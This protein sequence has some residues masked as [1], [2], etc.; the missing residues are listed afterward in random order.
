MKKKKSKKLDKKQYYVILG[1][2]IL[3]SLFLLI[4][5]LQFVINLNKDY[6]KFDSRIEKLSEEKKK[7]NESD[8]TTLGW[9]KIQNTDID[10]PVIKNILDNTNYP[11]EVENYVWL[12][13]EEPKKTNV[14]NIMGHNIMNL[15]LN[16]QM[17][18]NLFHRFEE[19]MSFVY[20]DF[21]KESKY[22]QL[23][24]DGQD[25]IYKVISVGFVYPLDVMLFPKKDYS[26]D[27]IKSYLKLLKTISIYDYD[28]DITE[29]DTFINLI[30]CT[31]MFG[32]SNETD[33][34]VSARKLR[35][36]EKIKDYKVKK[37]KNYERVD[38]ALKGVFEDETEDSV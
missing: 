29:D 37:N 27:E 34:I 1:L 2:L 6:Y 24:I 17:K 18:S 3:L 31:R 30:T 12:M 5:L 16:P 22:I 33:F 28:V 20:Y 21:A 32:K 10:L 4:R 9:L 11:V 36:N 26:K 13:N 7:D 23:T 8:H 14:M 25:E 19:L 35:K 38:N 15:G